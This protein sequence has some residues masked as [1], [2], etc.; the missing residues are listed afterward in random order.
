M[1]PIIS[2]ISEDGDVY[3]FTLSGINVSLVNAIRRT[4]LSD[5]P[6]M[7]FDTELIPDQQNCEIL[8]NT[9]RLHNEI[10]KA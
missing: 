1:N 9:G 4:I 6:T 5:I 8:I 7:A 3:K 2:N 10:L